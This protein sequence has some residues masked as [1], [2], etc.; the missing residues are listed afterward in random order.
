MMKMMCQNPDLLVKMFNSPSYK[1][2][3]EGMIANPA[4]TEKVT[5]IMMMAMTLMMT[6]A[7][8][9]DGE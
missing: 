8:M 7:V 9:G 3:I 5:M 4:W 1:A 2:M 6:S